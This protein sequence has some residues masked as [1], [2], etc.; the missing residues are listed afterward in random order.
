MPLQMGGWASRAAGAAA[1][2]RNGQEVSCGSGGGG[3]G[4]AVTGGEDGGTGAAADCLD[5][6]VAVLI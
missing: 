6:L 3:G 4:R 5:W 1:D 2:V